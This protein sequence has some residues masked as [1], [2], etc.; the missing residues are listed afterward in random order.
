MQPSQDADVC[1][2]Q[3]VRPFKWLCGMPAIMPS[4]GSIQDG[5]QDG[6]EMKVLY[7][8]A[9]QAWL[10]CIPDLAQF[11]VL[12]KSP[13][14]GEGARMGGGRGCNILNIGL[15]DAIL[16]EEGVLSNH[17]ISSGPT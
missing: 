9:C 13:T 17:P 11:K 5:G 15:L 4:S 14:W 7:V 2:N 12:E 1:A 8:Q 10:L 6:E 3:K 16:D